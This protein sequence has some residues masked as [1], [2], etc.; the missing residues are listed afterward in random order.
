MAFQA[1]VS[2]HGTVTPF[3]GVLRSTPV[4]TVDGALVWANA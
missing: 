1:W 3:D 4:L 2:D